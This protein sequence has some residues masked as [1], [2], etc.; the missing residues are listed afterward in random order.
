MKT[1]SMA[2]VFCLCT[3]ARAGEQ[4]PLVGKVVGVADGDTITVLMNETEYKV[5]LHGIDAPER[6]QPYSDE[7]KRLLSDLVFGKMVTVKWNKK[8]RNQ[9]VLGDVHVGERLVHVNLAMVESGFAWHYKQF[10]KDEKLA[11]AQSEAQRERRGLWAGADPVP[12]WEYR[13]KKK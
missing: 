8:D 2:V 10:S 11:K 13:K 4:K 6:F 3:L 5:R 1:R 12:P 7:S 9:R